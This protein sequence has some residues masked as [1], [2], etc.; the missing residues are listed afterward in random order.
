MALP[1]WPLHNARGLQM[2]RTLRQVGRLQAPINEDGI[3]EG[4]EPQPNPI[5][6]QASV[7]YMKQMSQVSSSSRAS[8]TIAP[9]EHGSD[10]SH[11]AFPS[12]AEA[13]ASLRTTAKW[14]A[15]ASHYLAWAR[16]ATT[17][18]GRLLLALAGSCKPLTL[19]EERLLISVFLRDPAWVAIFPELALESQQQMAARLGVDPRLEASHLPTVRRAANPRYACALAN[20]L[21][22]S[23]MHGRPPPCSLG[24][25]LGS[26]CAESDDDDCAEPDDVADNDAGVQTGLMGSP[27]IHTRSSPWMTLESLPES[28]DRRRNDDYRVMTMESIDSVASDGDAGM[29]GLQTL[30]SL[31]EMACPENMFPPTADS[32]P[33]ILHIIGPPSNPHLHAAAA[34]WNASL[35]HGA[36]P[37]FGPSP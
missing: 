15:L 27:Q 2:P 26:A 31:P 10:S 11:G 12:S 37:P 25:V 24:S 22:G 17:L 36:Y 20:R 6:Q 21:P 34:H 28:P 33:D 16:K 7:E 18:A 3:A 32:L 4:M 19:S 30:D 5:F 14:S 23:S 29:G 1:Q 8:R 35:M 9:R 13:L